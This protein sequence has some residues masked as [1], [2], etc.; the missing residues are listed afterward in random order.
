[1]IK[2][3]N[4]FF[5]SSYIITHIGYLVGMFHYFLTSLTFFIDYEESRDEK[6]FEKVKLRDFIKNSYI[7]LSIAFLIFGMA[8]L[9]QF[10]SHC[11]LASLRQK[12]TNQK[13]LSSNSKSSTYGLPR[14][15]WFEYVTCPHYFAEIL[16]YL[17]FV[18]I[19]KFNYGVLLLFF[20]VV[21][22]LSLN[23]KK[24]H[25]WYFNK[26]KEVYPKSRKIMIPFLW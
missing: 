7:N 8:N 24:S 14:G 22:N 25:Q 5:H 2:L 3:F 20:W 16:I 9:H 26:F 23:A 21:L 15:D 4:L 19:M 12:K 10:R 18:I 17:S 13:I 11:I 6:A 1:M